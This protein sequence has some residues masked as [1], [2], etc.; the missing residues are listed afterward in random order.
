VS[1]H[2]PVMWRR[3]RL[4]YAATL[5]AIGSLSG[6]YDPNKITAPD[7]IFSITASPQAIAANGFSTSQITAKVTPVHDKAVKV[8]FSSSGG[9]LSGTTTEGRAPDSNG[10]VMVFLKSE[11]TPK[12]VVVTAEAR[13]GTD[14]LAS[15]SVSVTFEAAL[16]DS[17]IKLTADPSQIEAD[18]VARVR[19][20][21]EVNTALTNRAVTFKTTNGSFSA[22]ADHPVTEL[23]DQATGSDGVAVAE[24]FGVT[25]VGTALITATAA[26]YSATQ[27]VTF[28]RAQPDFMSV[29]AT[30]L[31]IS[32]ALETNTVAISAVVSRAVGTVTPNTRVDFVAVN[33]DSSVSFGR[34]QNVTR[35]TA[36][37]EITA[38]F[39]PGVAAPLGLATITARVPDNGVTARVKITILP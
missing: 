12:T 27:T 6:C 11:I 39:V 8:F 32:R 16:P 19:L 38:Q 14:V 26:G 37:G 1:I 2:I 23:K 25:G 18:G 15:R 3:S 28:T 35:S 7:E 13:S 21:A 29:Q 9:T 24:L 17:V 30:P 34:F 4:S 33:D 20:R 31:A 10:D 22:D 36:T 5:L